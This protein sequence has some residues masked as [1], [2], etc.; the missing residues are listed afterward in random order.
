MFENSTLIAG[1]SLPANAKLASNILINKNITTN[2][3]TLLPYDFFILLF[4]QSVNIWRILWIDN[5]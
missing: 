3:S 1:N 4:Q 5:K 2:T